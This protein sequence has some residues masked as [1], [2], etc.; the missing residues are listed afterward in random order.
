MIGGLDNQFA[1]DVQGVQSL[2]HSVSRDPQAGLRAA[3]TQFEALFMQM[4]LKSMREASPRAGL[5][6][7]E[8]S[9]F[10]ES[11]MDQQWVQ[12]LAGSGSGIG[13]AEQ[14]IA[15]LEGQL[16]SAPPASGAAPDSE[17]NLIAGIPRGEPVDLRGRAVSLPPRPVTVVEESAIAVAVPIPE[18]PALD[19]PLQSPATA[20][21]PA[22]AAGADDAEGFMAR[23][24]APAESA[25][26]ATG[27]PA[28]LIL[29]QAALET[30]WGRYRIT[31]AD[32][33]DSHN[34]FGIKAGAGWRGETTEVTTHEY[35]NGRRTRV[36]EAFRV[37]ESA[38]AA[39][40]DY[41]QLIRDNPRYAAV[42]G[43]GNPEQAARA[44]QAGGYAT[45]PAYAD[46][47][48]AV[49]QRSRAGLHRG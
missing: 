34:L 23:L 5:L 28:E 9:R 35:V 47:L 21:P 36:S 15:Q 42:L 31:T 3:A 29:A 46:K 14:L 18:S 27:V 38:E 17:D 41:A 32:G 8:Q 33:G 16:P 12:H 20:P 43:A 24:R 44:L 37:Y 40:T 6:D 10:Y 45:D 1:L 30:G 19:Q 39:F 25:S 22:T 26:R 48:I 7:S 4:M 11:L 13:L 49:M 2:K